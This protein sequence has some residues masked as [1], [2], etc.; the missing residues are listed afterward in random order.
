MYYKKIHAGCT[1]FIK[2]GNMELEYRRS[3]FDTEYELQQLVDL[4]NEV[5][6]D[7]GIHFTKEG[8]IRRYINNPSG[9]VLSFNAF[10]GDK[11]VAHYACIPTKMVIDGH[12]SLGMLS[13]AT[14]THPDYRGRGLFRM[15]AGMTYSYGAENGYEFVIGVANANSFPGFIKH[16]NFKF[17]AQLELK[18]GYCLNV[19]PSGE[20]RFQGFYDRDQI[21]WR[22]TC[23]GVKYKKAI[24]HIVGTHGKYVKTYMGQFDDEILKQCA[25][26]NQKLSLKPM[27]YVGLGA[28]VTGLCMDMPKFV[29]HSPFNLIF[30]DLTG[31][32]LPEM[33]KDN[34]FFQLWDYDV[35]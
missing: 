22:K 19:R 2:L 13:M 20:K 9:R 33:T 8:F 21:E 17:I 11:M 24:D 12:V 18:I 27:L 14:V 29:K 26:P 31:G 23:G 30:R 25:L 35:A 15:L 16:L 6:K 5:Y 4:Q 10:D 28:K 3:T 34:V 32:K 7:R 1:K